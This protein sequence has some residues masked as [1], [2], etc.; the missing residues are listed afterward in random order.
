MNLT[1]PL[2]I[3]A[4][5]L[6]VLGG[7]LRL[8]RFMTTDTLGEWI[9][10]APARRWAAGAEERRLLALAEV[11]ESIRAKRELGE[12]PTAGAELLL[13]QWEDDAENGRPLSFRGRLVSGLDCPFCIG[14]WVGIVVI[15]ATVLLL[16]YFPW[17]GVIWL[18]VLGAL[19]L[20]YVAG[21]I[22]ARLD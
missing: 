11:T 8:T 14:F 4:I 13:R 7:T 9:V 3:A 18:G 1:D 17:A 12:E 15:V 6:L 21:H 20:N 5:V 2:L 22:S 16:T 10:R 19:T